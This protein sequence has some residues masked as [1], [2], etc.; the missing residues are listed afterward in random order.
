[1]WDIYWK[2]LIMK[3]CLICGVEIDENKK[4]CSRECYNKKLKEMLISRNKSNTGKTW[5]EIM[6]E[7]LSNQRRR[8]LSERFKKDNPSSNPEVAKKISEKLKQYRKENPLKGEK[9]PFYGRKHTEEYRK[10][11]S[12]TKKG[13]RSYN[14]EQYRLQNEK[15]LKG[16]D[17]PNWRGGISNQ[18]YPFGFN[19]TLKEE[20]KKR[21]EFKC[22]VC[23]KETQKLAIHHINYDKDNINFDN[24]ISLCYSCHS[25]TNYNRESWVVFFNEKNK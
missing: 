10:N 6:G 5:D 25:K 16:D 19:K 17:H 18:P 9:N 15:T 3:N 22:G 23:N 1:M 13:K 2:R 20:I 24:L 11:A 14:E 8:E 12:E 7:T 21:D 4:Y